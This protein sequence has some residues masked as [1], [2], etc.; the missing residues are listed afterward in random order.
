MRVESIKRINIEQSVRESN[1]FVGV[2]DSS[3]VSVAT[4]AMQIVFHLITFRCGE[5]K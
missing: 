4:P 5:V 3:V 2:I 1:M